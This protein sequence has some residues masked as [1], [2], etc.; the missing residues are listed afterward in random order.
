LIFSKNDDG[1]QFEHIIEHVTG[2]PLKPSSPYLNLP[3][4]TSTINTHKH[5]QLIL[6][7]RHW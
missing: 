7:H 2:T 3:G 6:K 5:T 4:F 1:H